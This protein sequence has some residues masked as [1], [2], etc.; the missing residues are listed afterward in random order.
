MAGEHD[1][2]ITRLRYRGWVLVDLP[3]ARYAT[4]GNVYRRVCRIH[5]KVDVA[6][7]A[8]RRVVD[9]EEDG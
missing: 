7:S 1:G 2:G 8:F 6:L 4:K 9:A 5:E 3:D